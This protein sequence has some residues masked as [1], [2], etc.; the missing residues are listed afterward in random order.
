MT[1]PSMNMAESRVAWNDRCTESATIRS[2][3]CA[4]QRDL[5]SPFS[6]SP[7]NLK[8][9]KVSLTTKCSTLSSV[10]ANRGIIES[11]WGGETWGQRENQRPDKSLPLRERLN[12][13][14]PPLRRFSFR[15]RGSR[16]TF[17]IM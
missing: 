13:Y 15:I 11:E 17:C 2:S 8:G 3:N 16:H 12:E 9:D 4:L 10:I 1:P 7:G 6:P 5:L 14:S